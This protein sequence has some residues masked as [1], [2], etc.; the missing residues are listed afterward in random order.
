MYKNVSKQYIPAKV[1]LFCLC[2]SSYKASAQLTLTGQLRTRS[3]LRDGYATL[4]PNGNTTAAFVSQRTRLTFNYKTGKVIFQ[5]SLQDVR[6]WGQDASTITPADGSKLSVHE[7]WAE[8]IFSNKKDTSFKVSP[9]D[10]FA[11][12]IGRQ[13]LSYDDERL[14]GATDWLQQARRHDAI[15]FKLLQKGWQADLGLAFNQNTEAVNYNGTYYTPANVPVTVKDSKGNLINVPAGFIPLVSAAG[16]SSKTGAPVFANPPGTNA[17]NQN[18]KSLQYLYVAK[19]VDQTKLAFLFLADQFGK[20]KLDSVQNTA[21]ADVGYLYGRRFN[22][23]GTNTRI[24]TGLAIN[25]AFG[26]KKQWLINGAYYYQGGHDKDGAE[27]QAY[28]YTATLQLKAGKLN[29]TAGFDHLSGNDALSTSTVNHR[30]DPLYGTPHKFW[31]YMDYFYA[32]S[33]APTGGLN[34]PYLKAKYTSVNTRFTGELAAHYFALANNQKDLAGNAIDKYL[35][36]EVDLTLG[37]KLSKITN[38]DLGLSYMAA[39]SSME[40]AKG[41]TPGTSH[42]NP[43]WAYLQINIKPDFLNK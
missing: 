11:V 42:L 5:T 23:P 3:E 29:Y 17:L 7:A 13:E 39:S 8:L 27:L 38:V 35:G 31:G 2:L 25:S 10:Y 21:G 19:K 18:Y 16:I 12:K 4:K 41:I 28:H 15:V 36:T 14:L 33:G 1:M 32:V 30:F 20:Y 43:M 22:Q 37:Y 34:N 24:T 26:S 9:F 6:L 40:Y